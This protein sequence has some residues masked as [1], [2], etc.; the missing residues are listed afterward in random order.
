MVMVEP[1]LE[2]RLAL[3]PEPILCP[4]WR[5]PKP[6]HSQQLCDLAA[7]RELEELNVEMRKPR[8]RGNKRPTQGH[9]TVTQPWHFCQHTKRATG[10][11][12]LKGG[13]QGK[14]REQRRGRQPGTGR[15][16]P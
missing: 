8:P 5:L 16:G 3:L 13:T 15:W 12:G 2:L 9:T 7:P 4:A 6:P 14:Q 1:G 11:E 10:A